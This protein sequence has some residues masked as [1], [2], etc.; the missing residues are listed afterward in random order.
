MN[1]RGSWAPPQSDDSAPRTPV[2]RSTA[3]F[4]PRTGGRKV[5]GGV[6]LALLALLAIAFGS[7]AGLMLVYS[8]NLPQISEL[9][10]YRP[11]TTTDLYDIHGQVIGSFALQRRTN[12]TYDQFSPLLRE[13]VI[14]I[15]DKNFEKHG[16]VSLVRIIGAAY[17]DLRSKGR[18]QGASTI[19]MQL[20]RNLFLSDERTVSRKLQE[21]FLSIQIEHAFTK[22]QIFTL[23]GNQIYLGHGLYGFEA[24]SEYYF[25]KHAS[26]LTLPE[27]ALLAA[28]PKGPNE[29]SPILNPDRA[30]RRRNTVI[31]AMLEDGDITAAQAES[32]RTA[33][34]GL[35]LEPPPN[36]VAPWFVE[37]VRREL[38]SEY[39]S[40]R[41]HEAGLKVYTTLDLNLQQAANKAVEDGL[42]A[43]ER[44]RGWHARL[45]N[46]I[47]GGISLDDFKHPDWSQPPTPGS[48][49]HALVT[50][51]LP[52]QVAA[53]IGQKRLLLTPDNWTWTGFK[54]A[55]EFLH[56]GDIIYVHIT[57][58]DNGALSA[59]LEEDTGAQGALLAIDN[60]TGG[61]LAMVGGRDFNLSQFNRATQAERQTGSS[62]KPYVYTAA[63]EAG[64]TPQ[65][66]VLDTPTSFGEWIPHNYEGNYLG[67][68]TLTKAFADSRNI[69][70]VRLADRVGIKNVIE[71]AHRFG[72]TSNIPPYLPIALGAVEISL[73]EQV[74][75][76]AVFPNDG[77]RVA[78]R[79]V[80]RVT[81]ADGLPLSQSTPDV[82]EVTSQKTARAMMT[83][84]RAV[85]SNG[86][87][88]TAAALGV[89][90]GGKT[91]TTSDF[92]DAWFIG[93]SPSVTCG[94]WTG[95]DN[96]HSLGDKETGARVAL[97]I[98]MEF[99]K[100]AI[101]GNPDRQ[102]PGEGPDSQQMRAQR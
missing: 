99:M 8:V 55:D 65:S 93:F 58:Q 70:A 15:E 16:G 27:A 44:S 64:E 35:H 56:V 62:F 32:A 20:A 33:P 89:P 12:I 91:G 63:I 22:P 84:F 69:P 29:Y 14:S 50:N 52:Y 38:V 97:P 25:S 48:Y 18:A 13:A 60:A 41:V 96:R 73:E 72:V 21:I 4:R 34:L 100:V 9:E 83:M 87:A 76:Y 17:H 45:L 94:V 80:R 68:I 43:Y 71:T 77:V 46:V 7:L 24:A 79:L 86:T 74:A 10:R 1:K 101:S 61:V 39:G 53:R 92:T 6:A 102:F 28:L 88:S 30:F 40:D 57:G 85:T 23:Y 2:P 42:A 26:D 37:E 31:N 3:S 81:T 66:K 59:T 54:T 51:V 90:V 11:I 5:A 82:K 75:A 19:T 67:S 78:P 98:W 36:S 49:M 47:A 95:Y